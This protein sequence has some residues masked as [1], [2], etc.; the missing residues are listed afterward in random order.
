VNLF[1]DDF[2]EPSDAA[3]YMYSKSLQERY[4][5]EPWRVARN[6]A[7][8]VDLVESEG[9]PDFVSFD[10][11]LGDE[12]YLLAN[13]RF[14]DWYNYY[15]DGDREFTGYDCAKW[16]INYCINNNYKLPQYAVHS[17]NPVG[18]DN[19]VQYLESYKRHLNDMH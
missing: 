5:K 2:R 1:L 11:D 19:I 4:R 6:Y 12:H 8:F 18:R 17:Q 16:L 7:Q 3:N 13:A 15:K 14:A 9:V 10:H